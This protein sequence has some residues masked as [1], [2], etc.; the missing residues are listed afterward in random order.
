MKNFS[1]GLSQTKI[2]KPFVLLFIITVMIINT[3]AQPYSLIVSKSGSGG[4]TVSSAPAGISCGAT[5]S[6][7]FISGT[8]VTLTATP[9]ATSSFTGWSGAASGTNSS[10][11]ISMSADKSVNATFTRNSYTLNILRSGSGSGTVASS[12]SGI[13]CGITCSA[14]YTAG[15]TVTLVATPSAGSVF[16]GWSGGGCSGTGTCDVS[17]MSANSVTA[18]FTYTSNTYY[19]DNDGDGYGTGDV[20]LA[21]SQ[22]PN[23]SINNLDCDDTEPLVNPSATEICGNGTDED[24][25]GQLDD[26]DKFALNLS[27]S[28]SGGGTVSSAP[29]GIN[30]GATCSFLFPSGSNITL[31][32]TPD[33]TSSFTGWSGAASGT[34]SSQ[35]IS[36]SANRTVGATFTRNSYTLNILR[37][38][39]GSGTV[40]SSPSGIDCGITCSASYTAGTTVTLV[41]T[42]SAGSVFTGWSGGGCSGTGTCDVSM[43]SANS[44]TADF[45]ILP[46]EPETISGNS[47]I[48]SGTIQTYSIGTVPNA[49]AYSWTFPAGWTGSST[50]NSIDAATGNSGVISVN[51][52]NSCG[53][54]PSGTLNVT[55]NNSPNN[56]DINSGLVAYYPFDNNSN[57]ESGNGNNGLANNVSL[58]TDR[59]GNP[60]EAFSFNGTSSYIDLG[61][62]DVLNPHKNS[63]TITA[64]AK[65]GVLNQHSRILSKGTHG[66]PQPG[67]DL[68]FYPSAGPTKAAVILS[69][70]GHEHIV[71]SNNPINDLN[72]HFYAGVISRQGYINLYV[73]GIKQNDSINI[74]NHQSEDI[75]AGTYK[76]FIGASY[77]N[78]GNPGPISEYFNGVIDDVR[79]YMRSLSKP[80][81]IG[82][83]HPIALSVT[84][85][86]IC[87][88]SSVD[89]HLFN[90]Q[91]GISYQ[92]QNNGSAL[93]SPQTGDGSTLLFNT[94]SL[95][96]SALLTVLATSNTSLCNITLDTIIEVN[97]NPVYAFTENHAICNGEIYNWQGTDYTEAGTYVAAYT[98]IHG[99]DSIYTLNLTVNPLYEFT[100]DYS[101]CSG[102]IY[103]WQGNDYTEAGTYVAAYNTIHGCD[104]IYTLNLTVHPVYEFT[105]NDSMCNGQTYTWQG[106]DYT[107]AGTYVAAYTTVHGCDSIYNL[108]LIV[109]PVYEFTEEYVICDG[110]TYTWQDNDY[111]DAGTYVAAYNTINGCDSIYT[112]NLTVYPA[113]EFTEEYAI[114]EG[115]T[116]IWQGNN[117]TESGT[118]IAAYTTIHGCDSIYSINL[119]VTTV[120]VSVTVNES[121]IT[122]NISGATYQWVDCDNAYAHIMGETSQSFTALSNGNYAV[123]VTKSSCLD[124][125]LCIPITV[126][127]IKSLQAED[128]SIYPNPVSNKLF[129]EIKGNKDLSSFEILNTVGQ[130]VFKGS[131]F[132]MTSVETSSFDPGIY[133]VKIR[134]N[135]TTEIRKIIIE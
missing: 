104:S 101:I 125:S 56:L 31:T 113:Y 89:I 97:V 8:D 69:A 52:T 63:I 59:F 124:T 112:L 72:W 84:E 135:R 20:I 34:N 25:S 130:I 108:N 71:Y 13:D 47:Q 62:V 133:L 94:G 33:G 19:A 5:C 119:T 37:S 78:F 23:T 54:G 44:V 77:S 27:K 99:C 87:E 134:H 75:G 42:P 117:Y 129:I 102:D 109:H 10:Q 83:F 120:D 88:N 80:E 22:P 51:A 115:E 58:T 70:G 11:T 32:A 1:T 41:A 85:D 67:Y 38:G 21:G 126:I 35:T 116:Y 82:I 28:G 49:S 96:S 43:M 6:F 92:L 65:K 29:A 95:T 110:E 9:D 73:D 48:C 17:M 90:S 86:S 81:V 100:E 68:M 18:Q 16:T 57:D 122:A 45:C 103:T 4:G 93:G 3:K 36:M 46:G 53:T 118:Y 60:N 79:V 24:C 2:I 40:A 26:C 107:E 66:G 76:A 64:W 7:P 123:E 127:D 131:L 14:S 12:P 106:N 39:S 61:D 74:S 50:T 15:T 30:C 128:I 114:C 91:N 105:E 55:V 121:V 98:T 111:I 132:E